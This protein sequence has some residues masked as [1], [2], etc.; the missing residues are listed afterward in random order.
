MVLQILDFLIESCQ[1]PHRPNQNFLIRS[2][3]LE[4][5]ADYIAELRATEEPDSSQQHTFNSIEE[6]IK[7]SVGVIFGILDGN[8]NSLEIY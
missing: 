3:F 4:Y 6:I 7:K 8:T 5:L 2:K 1:G